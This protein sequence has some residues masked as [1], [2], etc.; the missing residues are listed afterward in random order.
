MNTPLSS[1]RTLIAT[2]FGLVEVLA[3]M[4]VASC[5]FILFLAIMINFLQARED[6]Q[7]E[8]RSVVE[9]GTMTLFFIGIYALLSF[10]IGIISLQIIP[11]RVTNML[12]GT[13]IIVF[14][15][16]F[17]VWGR[18]HLKGNWANQIRIY[19]KQTLVTSGPYAFVR[20]PLYASLIWMFYGAALL[21]ANWAV[22]L[23]NTVIFIPF[24][25]WRAHGEE[26]MLTWR[27]PEYDA[28]RKRTGMFF[29]RLLSYFR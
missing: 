15:T 28:Y 1:L 29:P 22:A 27:F 4:L 6:V 26:E 11:L 12:I 24:M 20:H 2:P 18:I 10:R 23:A 25:W 7:R 9:T 19:A 14:G 13:S 17:N 21:Y 3:N 5:V 8:H 16:C